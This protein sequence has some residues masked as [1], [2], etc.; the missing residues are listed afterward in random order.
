[1]IQKIFKINYKQTFKP[2]FN[3]IIVVIVFC[4]VINSNNLLA[5]EDKKPVIDNDKVKTEN[6]NTED[7]IT[8]TKNNKT[9][10]ENSSAEKKDYRKDLDRYMVT[11]QQKVQKNWQCPKNIGKESATVSFVIKKDGRLLSPQ[12]IQSSK[13]EDLN[14]AAI[15]AIKFAAPYDPLPESYPKSTLE[16]E[17]K[18][19]DPKHK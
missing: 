9:V 3:L 1:M 11:L 8:K 19:E 16:I 13:S 5:Q 10:S 15:N 17:L 7:N 14:K 18:F 12:L 4:I 2:I 6:I